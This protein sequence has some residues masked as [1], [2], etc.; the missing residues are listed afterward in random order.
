[1]QRIEREIPKSV[2]LILL[3]NLSKCFKLFHR[4]PRYAR[5]APPAML[6]PPVIAR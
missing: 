5:R 4:F 3:S 1:V 2:P 6:P